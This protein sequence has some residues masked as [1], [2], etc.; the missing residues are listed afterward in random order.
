MN[1]V[2]ESALQSNIKKVNKLKLVIGKL[3]MVMPDSLEFCFQALS[4]DEFFR[5]AV[6]EIEQREILIRC[7][8]CKGQSALEDAYYYVCPGCG[9]NEVEII[10]GRELY[11]D[12]YEG[13]EN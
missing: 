12:Y 1:M 10:Q 8:K 11:L 5:D 9:S 7:F 13:E 6:M 3:S 2:R 4:Q